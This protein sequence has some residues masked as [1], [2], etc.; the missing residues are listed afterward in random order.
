MSSVLLQGQ[1]CIRQCE[2]KSAMKPGQS[3]KA[4]NKGF[5]KDSLGHPTPGTYSD[6]CGFVPH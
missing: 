2:N 6:R 3:F 4:V 5:G 1:N